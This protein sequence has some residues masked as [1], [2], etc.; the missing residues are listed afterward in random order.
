MDVDLIMMFRPRPQRRSLRLRQLG[1]ASSVAVGRARDEARHGARHAELAEVVQ[2]LRGV[3]G[4]HAE[5]W[6]LQGENRGKTWENSMK[7]IEPCWFYMVLKFYMVF[8]WFYR[9]DGGLNIG[10]CLK[11]GFASKTLGI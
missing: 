4:A 10:I 11:I 3:P 7:I 1:P 5:T 6:R 2:E 8:T 9:K